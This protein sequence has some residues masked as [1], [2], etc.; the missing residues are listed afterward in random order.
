M[1]DSRS[2]GRADLP[3]RLG[4]ADLQVHTNAGDGMASAQEALAWAARAG[5]DIIAI[6]DHDDLRGGLQALETAARIDSPVRVIPGLEVT[7]RAGHLL[8]LFPS[9]AGSTSPERTPDVPPLRPL[10]WTIGTVHEQGGVCIVPHPLALLPASVGTR[11]LDPLAQGPVETRPDGIELANPAP[12]AR[13]RGQAARAANRGWGFAETGGS[14]AHFPEAIGSAL[15]RFPGLEIADLVRALAAATTVAEMGVAPS[16]RT[17]GARR[18]LAQQARGLSAT[19]RALARRARQRLAR[20]N[21]P[22]PNA[23]R[24][25]GPQPSDRAQGRTPG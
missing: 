14:D 19:P 13:W 9:L 16:L 1:T 25:S 22:N 5:L 17:I 2:L 7:T 24:P 21:R 4:R 12:P 23:H 10:G 8:A 6:T 11:A 15:T 20:P 18:L 3:R